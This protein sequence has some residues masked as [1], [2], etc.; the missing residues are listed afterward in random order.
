[1]LPFDGAAA[2]PPIDLTLPLRAG[3]PVY[4]GDPEVAFTLTAAGDFAVTAFALGTHTG[5]HLDAPRHALPAGAGVED[6]PLAACLGPARVADCTGLPHITPAALEA[7]LPDLEPAARVLL[8]TDWH[9][10]FGRPDYYTAF[11]PLTL[12][13]VRWLIRQRIC[14]LGLETPSVCPQHDHEAHALLLGAG[15]VII[16]GLAG[17]RQIPGERCWFAALPLRLE[18][19]DG[20]PVR[21]VAWGN[22]P[23]GAMAGGRR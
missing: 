2:S 8:R 16:E 18:G 20:S 22:G 7:R 13:A 9:L 12:P 11:P 1:M 23:M 6:V 21:A 17:L 10:A 15:V 5:T 3:M 14:L 4:P 19:L